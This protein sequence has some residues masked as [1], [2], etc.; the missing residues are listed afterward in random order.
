M[1]LA[2]LLIGQLASQEPKAMKFFNLIKTKVT[3]KILHCLDHGC[4]L[5]WLI[6]PDER[7]VIV[8]P[9]EQ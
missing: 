1:C 5:D 9:S 4:L 3:K 7:S 8:H 6:D 2:W